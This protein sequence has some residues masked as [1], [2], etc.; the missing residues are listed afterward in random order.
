M[1][2]FTQMHSSV[3]TCKLNKKNVVYH[4]LNPIYTMRFG[5]MQLNEIESS[6]ILYN[7]SCHRL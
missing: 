6:S 2:M 1:I 3:C 7:I 4:G 5:H